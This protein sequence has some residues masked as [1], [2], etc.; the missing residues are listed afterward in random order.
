M[1]RMHRLSMLIAPVKT[2]LSVGCAGHSARAVR[3]LESGLSPQQEN[4][5]ISIKQARYFALK[6]SPM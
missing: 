6:F 5:P 3:N 4:H 1:T 2:C